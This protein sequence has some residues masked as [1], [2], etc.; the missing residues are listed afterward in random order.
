MVGKW[1]RLREDKQPPK[2]DI[3]VSEIRVKLRGRRKARLIRL[4][5]GRKRWKEI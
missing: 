4:I 2:H 5:K 1:L 3:W